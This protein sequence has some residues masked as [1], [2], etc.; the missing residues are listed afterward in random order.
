MIVTRAGGVALA[1]WPRLAS[2]RVAATT[3]PGAAADVDGTAITAP[4]SVDD[5]AHRAVHRPGQQPAAGA[6]RSRLADPARAPASLGAADQRPARVRRGERAASSADQ[7]PI[8][9]A[10]DD[11]MSRSAHREVRRGARGSCDH[12]RPTFPSPDDAPRRRPSG[13]RLGKS[14]HGQ[15]TDD[16]ASAEGTSA[17]HAYADD[18]TTSARP[19]LRRLHGGQVTGGSG[20]LSVPAVARSQGRRRRQHRRRAGVSALPGLA[21]PAASDAPARR[22]CRASA[23]S[24]WSTVMDRLRAGAARG[25]PSRPTDRS[26]RTCS[27]RPTR[28]SRRS[29]PATATHLREELGDLLLQVYFHARI[30]AEDA[31]DRFD[32]DDVA[33]G[34]VDKLVR[35][36]P[37][38]FA[39]LTWPTPT[40][41]AAT[42]SGSRPPRRAGPRCSTASRR[43]C[44]RWPGRQDRGPG[45]EGRRRRRAVAGVTSLGDRLL[46]LV[47]EAGARRRRPRAG[48]ARRRTPTRRRRPR[49][50]VRVVRDRN[51]GP[52]GSRTCICVTD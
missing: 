50:R 47:V 10:V 51:A 40:R 23:C 15:T 41:S 13:A 27:R 29:T 20:S 11:A 26:R 16:D 49:R 8:T 46:G 34:I 12:A 38:V 28:C 5:I 36:H 9:A 4:T 44:R 18:A 37:H 24:T 30:A 48:A 17:A 6:D 31:R 3:H 19:A 21:R 43:R 52:E 35:R 39:G 1:A 33:G 14:G 42:G 45:G 7:E 25:T 2:H 22:R 32:I